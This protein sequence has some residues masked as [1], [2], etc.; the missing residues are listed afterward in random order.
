MA[1]RTGLSG[2][3][4][5]TELSAERLDLIHRFMSERPEDERE[6]PVEAART[7]RDEPPGPAAAPAPD[8]PPA[9]APSSPTPSLARVGQLVPPFRMPQIGEMRRRRSQVAGLSMRSH[10]ELAWLVVAVILALLIGVLIA[11]SV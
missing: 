5:R 10:G 2:K 6:V 9:P 8:L 4:E 11:H 3:S 7:V 1:K